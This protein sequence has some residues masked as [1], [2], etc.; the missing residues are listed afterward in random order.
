MRLLGNV[1]G[2]TGDL[3]K[4][5]LSL[6]SI[7][8]LVAC[9]NII[10]TDQQQWVPRPEIE[11]EDGDAVH[12]YATV[13]ATRVNIR[14]LPTVFSR[15]LTQKTAPDPVTVV[16][17]FGVWSRLHLLDV[18]SET[19]IS[20]GLIT[21]LPEQ[22]LTA[23]MKLVYL[24]LLVTGAMGLLIAFFRPKWITKAVDLLL[25]TQELPSHAKPLISVEP[26][27]HPARD[28]RG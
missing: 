4:I 15:V 9:T 16:C 1:N 25:Q 7:F 13:N 12:R 28:S 27:F 6:F 8:F 11:C 22:P 18:G 24:G 14:D 10:Q 17:E 3:Q 20:S 5:S 19:W 23:R 2:G 21:L 26:Q